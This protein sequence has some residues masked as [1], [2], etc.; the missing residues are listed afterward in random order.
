MIG[1]VGLIGFL[2]ARAIAVPMIRIGSAVNRIADNDYQTEIPYAGR[3]DEVGTMSKNVEILR[4]RLEADFANQKE[5]ASKGSAFNAASAAMMTIDLDFKITFVNNALI[6][7][8]RENLPELQK[9]FPELDPDCLI[10]RQ[11][12]GFHDDPQLRR[13]TMSARDNLPIVQD[14]IMGEVRLAE[15]ISA[16]FDRSGDFVGWCV[17]WDNNIIANTNASVIDALGQSQAIIEF[18]LDGIVLNA[19]ENFLNAMDVKASDIIGKSHGLFCPKSDHE[20]GSFAQHWSNLRRGEFLRGKFHRVNLKGEEVILQASYNPVLNSEGKPYKVVKIATDITETEQTSSYRKKTLDAIGI[21]QAVFELSR[22]G[23][24]I[25]VNEVFVDLL[26]YSSDEI[27]GEHYNTLINDERRAGSEHHAFLAALENG[28]PQIGTYKHVAKDGSEVILQAMFSPV[29]ESDGSVARIVACASDVTASELERQRR[30]AELREKDATQTKVVNALTS[31]LG[32]LA[33]GE[34]T[35]QLD[36]PFSAEY[37]QLRTNFNAAV[38]GLCSTMMEAVLKAQGIRGGTMQIS[39]SSDDLARRT[40]SQAGSLEETAAAIEELTSSVKSASERAGVAETASKKAQNDAESGEMV[41]RDTIEAMTEIDKSSG[42]ISEIIGVIDD[43]AFQTNLLALNAGVEAARAGE[44]G[45]GFAVVA[46]EVRA[47]AQRCSDAAKEIKDLIS[48]SGGHVKRGVDL[49]GKTGAALEEINKSVV[50]IS[51]LVTSISTSSKEQSLG[52]TDINSSVAQLDE[53]TQQNAAM[54]EESTAASHEL[55]TDANELVAMMEHFK[56][57]PGDGEEVKWRDAERPG[58][59]AAAPRPKRPEKTRAQ[60]VDEATATMGTTAMG[61]AAM[62]TAAL[63][64][65][66]ITEDDGW[67]DF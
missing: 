32:A 23:N 49:V 65:S 30:G 38:G 50:E 19:N 63:D 40:E 60:P 16:I 3:G 14:L 52:L 62:G 12:E 8:I 1:V 58:K 13:R 55:T 54:V 57:E 42:K 44:A 6:E 51:G 17:E 47:L 9:K 28:E 20:D 25:G 64:P 31:G 53:V 21:H 7:L 67:E 10:G 27:I 35:F 29:T 66:P 41:V 5:S 11:F 39:Q 61:T 26:G 46:S 56:I 22:D 15:C 4:N 33:A 59:P 36:E 43:I 45:R 37:E 2:A 24:V 18:S 34:L 48:E